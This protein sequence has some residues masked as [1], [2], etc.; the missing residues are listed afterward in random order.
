[1]KKYRIAKLF[2]VLCIAGFCLMSCYKDH[3]TEATAHIPSVVKLHSTYVPMLFFGEQFIFE[4]ELGFREGN[5]TIVFSQ[6]DYADYDYVWRMSTTVRWDIANT[7]EVGEG[8]PLDM[9]VEANL[10]SGDNLYTLI[11]N[12]KHKRTDMRY[13]LTWRAAVTQRNAVRAGLMVADTRNEQTS[14][15][16]LIRAYHYSDDMWTT[17]AGGLPQTLPHIVY[18]NMF[19][20]RNGGMPIEGVVSQ[21]LWSKRPDREGE[22]AVIVRDRAYISLDVTT[23]MVRATN[24]QMFMIDPR[25]HGEAIKPQWAFTTF[26]SAMRHN[27]TVL[28]NDNKM[29]SYHAAQDNDV[30]IRYLPLAIHPGL[31]DYELADRIVVPEILDNSNRGLM[32]DKKHGRIVRLHLQPFPGS[33]PRYGVGLLQVADSGKFDP[34]KLSDFDCIFATYFQRFGQSQR[35]EHRS[36]WLMRNKSSG[37]L[38]GYELLT[39]EGAGGDFKVE[40]LEIF[41]LSGCLEIDRATNFLT[42]TGSGRELFYT[43]D[44][45]LYVAVLVTGAGVAFNRSVYSVPEGEVITHMIAHLHWDNNGKTYWSVDNRR[46]PEQRISGGELEPGNLIT[47]ATHNAATGEGKV[48]ALP[49]SNPGAGTIAGPTYVSIWGGF[50]RITSIEQRH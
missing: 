14:D 42:L 38:Y 21:L 26:R 44:N 43:V 27:Y 39:M 18:R 20:E 29:W 10:T 34:A 12:M 6:S 25:S 13:T 41:D 3:S 1:M 19:S 46:N 9:L 16:S 7:T 15:I 49:R 8:W 36:L 32:F 33:E 24:E 5:D 37:K 45:T 31:T 47:I 40:G 30:L 2:T 50:G 22:V 48:Y 4:P 17:P 35:P 11:L 23:M 28:F